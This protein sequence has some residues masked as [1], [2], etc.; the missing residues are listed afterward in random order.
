MNITTIKLKNLT[1]DSITLSTHTLSANA[2]L[3]VFDKN[4][5]TTF[6]IGLELSMTCNGNIDEL[7]ES[8]KLQF[9]IDDV[10]IADQNVRTHVYLWSQNMHAPISV[11]YFKDNFYFN[12][13]TNQFIIKNP[14]NN[15]RYAVQLTEYI[16]P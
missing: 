2:S 7:C 5:L 16:S 9:I 12:M 10:L 3:L 8:G 4:D 1:S 15:K 6:D 13:K 14:L 11:G